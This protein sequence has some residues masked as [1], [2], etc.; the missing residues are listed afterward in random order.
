MRNLRPKSQ[1]TAKTTGNK[2]VDR[3][4]N[5]IYNEINKIINSVNTPFLNSEIKTKDGK[6]GDIRI[7]EDKSFSVDPKGSPSA[8]FL[9]AKTSEGWVRQYMDKTEHSG[10]S[11]EGTIPTAS[12][13]LNT[14]KDI[15]QGSLSFWKADSGP[16]F[17]SNKAVSQGIEVYIN[18]NVKIGKNAAKNLEVTGTL[19]LATPADGDASAE[20]ILVHDTGDGLVKKRSYAQILSDLGIAADEILD[21]TADQGS[22]NIHANN[23]VITHNQVTDF[24]SEVN[25]LAQVKID[26]LVDSAPGALDTLNELAAAL[27]DDASFSTTVTNSIA[28]KL[29]LAGGTMTGDLII[30]AD[31]KIKSDTDGGYNFIEFDADA[32]SPENQT[33]ISSITNVTALI[34]CNNNGTGEFHVMK[35]NADLSSATQNLFVVQSNGNVGIANGSPDYPLDVAGSAG[36]ADYLYHNGDDDTYI[37]YTADRLRFSVGGEILL[38]LLEDDSQDIVKLGDGGDVDININDDMF[39]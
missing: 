35:G 30:A 25:A 15:K 33:V 11:R 36:F 39:V 16:K 3:V 37:R 4:V 8:F 10:V 24:D 18:E 38:D 28:T 19:K 23:I 14:K 32:S 22:T 27:N 6:P 9:E 31:N 12:L 21:W 17:S 1:K 29:P 26:A 2:S 20:N 5:D 34:D 13:K 7:V